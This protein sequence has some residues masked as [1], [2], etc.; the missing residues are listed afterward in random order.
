MWHYFENIISI[1]I[2]LKSI[3]QLQKEILG[4]LKKCLRSLKNEVKL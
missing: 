2:Q 1:E 4:G 3:L